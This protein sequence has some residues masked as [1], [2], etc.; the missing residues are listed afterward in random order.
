MIGVPRACLGKFFAAGLGS[1][2]MLH[3]G[4]RI[5]S[6]LALQMVVLVE[7]GFVSSPSSTIITR[8]NEKTFTT[9]PPPPSAS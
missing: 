7:P 2:K 6:Y 3:R 4:E 8:K 9:P 1:D 5:L